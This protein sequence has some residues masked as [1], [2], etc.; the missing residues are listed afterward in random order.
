MEEDKEIAGLLHEKI[1]LEKR[2]KA[3]TERL[4]PFIDEMKAFCLEKQLRRFSWGE[5]FE[6]LYSPPKQY[7][8]L[9]VKMEQV[10]QAHPDWTEEKTGYERLRITEVGE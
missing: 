5:N 7:F 10:H 4:K 9:L 1:N 8:K 2:L 3:V 6:M